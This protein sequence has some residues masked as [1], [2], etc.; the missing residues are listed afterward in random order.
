ML[1]AEI[2]QRRQS[3]LHLSVG[4]TAYVWPRRYRIFTR[5]E[6]S[7]HT[8]LPMAPEPGAEPRPEPAPERRKK[9]L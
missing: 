4:M 2:S 5:G 8:A 3:L 1:Q 6:S 9:R 7:S